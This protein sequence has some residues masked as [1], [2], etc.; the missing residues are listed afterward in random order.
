MAR[1]TGG[2]GGGTAWETVR[3][4]QALAGPGENEAGERADLETGTAMG[5]LSRQPLLIALPTLLS[6]RASVSNHG[7]AD[8][9]LDDLLHEVSSPCRAS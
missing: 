8:G 9:R 3:R 5:R 1:R 4:F 6:V 2:R 7:N